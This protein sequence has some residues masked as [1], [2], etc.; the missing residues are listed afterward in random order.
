MIRKTWAGVLALSLALPSVVVS[1]A[2]VCHALF[3]KGV[4]SGFL[5]VGLFTLVV[6]YMVW[7]MVY[8]AYKRKN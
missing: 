3:K 7:M 4:I 1:A 6:G 2:Y 8:Y 5:A